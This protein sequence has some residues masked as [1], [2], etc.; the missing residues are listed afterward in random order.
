MGPR[1]RKTVK[2][3][4][5]FPERRTSPTPYLP[6]TVWHGGTFQQNFLYQWKCSVFV[7]VATHYMW[8]LNQWHVASVKE[9]E[10]DYKVYF[11]INLNSCMWLVPIVSANTRID[12]VVKLIIQKSSGSRYSFGQYRNSPHTAC[13]SSFAHRKEMWE[14]VKWKEP[15]YLEFRHS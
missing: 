11:Y 7:M 15:Q 9:E 5:R 12:F 3:D 1:I 8:L 13:Q 6:R 2:R 4:S 14:G 10:V